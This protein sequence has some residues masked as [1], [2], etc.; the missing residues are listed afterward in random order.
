MVELA[1]TVLLWMFVGVSC[2]TFVA[3]LWLMTELAR[4]LFK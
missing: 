3:L 2:L 1:V 4:G